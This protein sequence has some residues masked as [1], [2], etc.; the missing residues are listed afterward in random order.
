MG[1]RIYS[2]PTESFYNVGSFIDE[3][4][5]VYK[6]K[7]NCVVVLLFIVQG[8]PL[9]NPNICQEEWYLGTLYMNRIPFFLQFFP[10]FS[11][12]VQKKTST[13]LKKKRVA[14]LTHLNFN[15]ELI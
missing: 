1:G 9:K 12:I 8:T 14:V 5:I 7:R 4:K 6:I 11:N 13:T 3:R 15:G 2:I 10:L